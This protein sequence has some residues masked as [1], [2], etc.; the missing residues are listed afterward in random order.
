MNWAWGE[1]MV[2]AAVLSLDALAVGVAYG[3]RGIRLPALSL[4]FISLTCGLLFGMALGMG[5]LAAGVLG[6][7]ASRW[8]GGLLLIATGVWVAITPRRSAPRQARQHANL[9]DLGLPVRVLR[10]PEESDLDHSGAI[11]GVEALVIGTALALDS[12]GVGLASALGHPSGWWGAA[13]L[14]ALANGLALQLGMTWARFIQRR[15]RSSPELGISEFV[16]AA[17]LVLLGLLRL[18]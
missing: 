15:S 3:L 14:V 7:A 17:I 18:V 13:L 9:G 4:T 12:L 5:G 8:L 16:P 6:T 11:S 10:H 2:L 1:W